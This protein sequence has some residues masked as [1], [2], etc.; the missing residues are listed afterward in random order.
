MMRFIK[1]DEAADELREQAA[2]C[3]QLAR[4]ASTPRGASALVEVANHF[5]ADARR[6]DPRSERR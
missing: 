3:R 1:R 6:I 2:T 4:R 5:D